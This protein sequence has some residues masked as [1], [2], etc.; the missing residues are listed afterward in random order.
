[1]NGS[2]G[3]P[4]IAGN[5]QELFVVGSHVPGKKTISRFAGYLP[6]ALTAGKSEP[7]MVRGKVLGAF[8]ETG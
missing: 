7:V 5:D 1:L 6:S 2:I 4:R 8:F 3:L